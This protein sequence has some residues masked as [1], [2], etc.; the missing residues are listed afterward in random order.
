MRS[1]RGLLLLGAP[2]L[3]AALLAL[4]LVARLGPTPVERPEA[5]RA[6][7]RAPAT[8]FPRQIEA[9]PA[10]SAPPKPAPREA[11]TMAM[12]ENRLRSTYQNYRTAVATGNQPLQEALRPTLLK[13]RDATIR[14]A[15]EEL[16]RSKNSSDRE[17]AQKALEALRR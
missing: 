5:R 16:N 8:T 14:I 7:A 10:P 1:K 2:L 11:I 4:A 9:A 15:E 6:E 17:I 3:G 13:D 12:D